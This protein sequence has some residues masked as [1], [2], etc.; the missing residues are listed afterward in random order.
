MSGKAPAWQPGGRR[1]KRWLPGGRETP[2][3]IP[4]GA[5]LQLHPVAHQLRPQ[6][7]PFCYQAAGSEG[8]GPGSTTETR[9]L[10]APRARGP[11]EA[12]RRPRGSKPLR[13]GSLKFGRARACTCQPPAE[14]GPGG[15]A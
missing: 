7:P 11:P 13:A 2:D 4:A 8:R 15:R 14:A 3:P 6:P 12:A 5:R 9:V 1:D 10:D